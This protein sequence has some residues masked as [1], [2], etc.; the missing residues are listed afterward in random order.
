MTGSL[1]SQKYRCEHFSNSGYSFLFNQI[2]KEA[3]E[4][5]RLS[6]HIWEDN[7]RKGT[8]K[9][10]SVTQSILTQGWRSQMNFTV[11]ARKVFTENS[12][13]LG[14]W[15][16][17]TQH[18]YLYSPSTLDLLSQCHCCPVLVACRLIQSPSRPEFRLTISSF[19]KPKSQIR[20]DEKDPCH[21][22][23]ENKNHP[24]LVRLS[25]FVF[26]SGI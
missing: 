7:W 4:V 26:L 8:V 9:K 15:Y 14:H 18:R 24:G 25:I 19:G 21:K 1:S 20:W 23:E 2:L 5:Q 17:N 11:I 16:R 22:T 6:V 10:W 13:R 3:R 12:Y